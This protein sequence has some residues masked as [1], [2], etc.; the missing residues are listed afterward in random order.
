[1]L[2]CQFLSQWVGMSSQRW[3]LWY[4]SICSL[5]D[6]F[7][8]VAFPHIKATMILADV[9][10][11]KVSLSKK[12]SQGHYNP[13]SCIVLTQEITSS[14]AR[15]PKPVEQYRALSFYG[16]NIV[17]SEGEEWKKYRKISAPAFSD[18]SLPDL[19][20][21]VAETWMHDI[22]LLYSATTSLFGMKPLKSCRDFSTICGPDKMLFQWTIALTS[23]YLYACLII[24]PLRSDLP[25]AL[26]IALFVIGV[27]GTKRHSFTH[28]SKSYLHISRIWKKCF[29]ERGH[30]YPSWP[31]DILQRCFTHR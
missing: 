11:I 29:M 21:T 25:W 26:Q 3:V 27:A 7:Q 14:R 28:F 16:H 12:A 30:R 20:I 2:C 4:H 23:H 9:A 17:A 24:I 1:M 31:Y 6:I 5:S 13:G 22:F 10:V 15:F 8:V 19:E 18:V